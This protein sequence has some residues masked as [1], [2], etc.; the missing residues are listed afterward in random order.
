M[1]QAVILA[2]GESSRFWP[3]NKSNKSLIKIMGRPLI[4]YTIKGLE[5]AGIKEAIIV[6]DS[7]EEIKKELK[8]YEFKINIKY[9]VQNRPKG[10]GDALL[11]TEK[12]VNGEIL[13]LN[14]NHFEVKDLL[15]FLKNKKLETKPK[16]IEMILFSEQTDTPEKYGIIEFYKEK[17]IYLRVK[18][19]VE[20]PA[21]KKAPSDKR[22]VGIYILPHDFLSYLKKVPEEQ[23]SF[24]NAIDLYL[25]ENSGQNNLTISIDLTNRKEPSLKYPWDLFVVNKFLMDKY[26]KNKIAKSAKISKN[27]VIKGN[28]YIGEN[29]KVFEGAVIKGPCYIGDNGIV[30]NNSVVRD[31]TNIENK[32]MIGA[33]A[34]AARCIFQENVHIHSGYF[35]DSIFGKGCRVGA[36]TVTANVRLD[37]GIIKSVVKGEKI[38]TGLDS[39]GAIVGENTKIGINC[40]LMPGK[41]IGSNCIVGPDSLVSENIEDNIKYLSEFKNTKKKLINRK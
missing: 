34:E 27:A 12:L 9:V 21:R 30:G 6:Q 3:L 8:N 25:E 13:V 29:V 19:I 16:S 2:A 14:P 39:L 18:R 37:R 41:L 23:Y 33:L 22:I 32:G 31:Y 28:V 26:L 24:E 38:E 1:N 35:G 7:K 15:T 40:S 10:M 5:D 17:G 36:G 11:R 20:K 4:W